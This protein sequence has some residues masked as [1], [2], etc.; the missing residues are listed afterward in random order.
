M[1]EQATPLSDK[2]RCIDK[3]KFHSP[4]VSTDRASNLNATPKELHKEK[5]KMDNASHNT[6][7]R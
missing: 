3:N 4:K 7:V 1:D 6:G 2:P 5:D